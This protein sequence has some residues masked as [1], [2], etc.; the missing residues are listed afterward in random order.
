MRRKQQALVDSLCEA[1]VL[2]D[3][4]VA[5]Q[6]PVF[7]PPSTEDDVRPVVHDAQAALRAVG[8][9]ATKTAIRRHV[10][11]IHD[12]RAESA[13]LAIIEELRERA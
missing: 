7:D 5:A 11:K 12:E 9:P 2:L 1:L 10:Y 4:Y 6:T 8:A 13:A 3:G